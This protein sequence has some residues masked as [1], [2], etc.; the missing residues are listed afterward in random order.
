M[1]HS[2]CFANKLRLF[3]CQLAKQRQSWWRIGR[4]NFFLHYIV[5]IIICVLKYSNQVHF[6]VL[7]KVICFIC[8]GFMFLQK[9]KCYSPLHQK[10][11]QSESCMLDFVLPWHNDSQCENAGLSPTIL[12]HQKNW[13]RRAHVLTK[14]LNTA[15]ISG[16]SWHSS[17]HI[18]VPT[19][20]SYQKVLRILKRRK[21]PFFSM[22][23]IFAE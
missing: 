10:N 9:G 14:Y 11:W 1:S 2:W 8:K 20:G 6:F 18:W 7:F 3:F 13:H 22:F 19:S 15:L 5:H 12:P 23:A 4:S 21:K 17:P 16:L